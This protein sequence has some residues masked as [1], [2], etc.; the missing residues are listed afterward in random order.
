MPN[1]LIDIYNH[2]LGSKGFDYNQISD[3]VFIGVSMCCQ[4]G[5]KRELLRKGIK[6]DIS[7]EKENIDAPFGIDY[8]LWLPTKDNDAPTQDALSLGV[9]M[10][11]FLIERKIKVYIHCKN[12]H[13]RST[14]LFVAYLVKHGLR[15]E[16]AIEYIK[17]KRPAIHLN[18]IQIAA[19][20]KFKDAIL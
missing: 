17:N 15:I 11:A 4:F 18:K 13:G 9:K 20:K 6:A 16:D 2:A 8:F 14:T 3:E 1:K 19:V 10:L 12:G 5:F 7:L